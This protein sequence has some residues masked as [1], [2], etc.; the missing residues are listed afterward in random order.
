MVAE[1]FHELAFLAK[2]ERGT[3][4][5]VVATATWFHIMPPLARP[6]VWLPLTLAKE[7]TD[8]PGGLS[9]RPRTLPPTSP[10]L[11]AHLGW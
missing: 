9:V 10:L 11:S 1:V 4:F 2:G 7:A 5:W 8:R 6:R 3:G